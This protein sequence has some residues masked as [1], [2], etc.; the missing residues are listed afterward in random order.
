MKVKALVGFSGVVTMSKD[1][2]L[3]IK[4]KEIVEDL[5]QAGFVE[6]IKDTKKKVTK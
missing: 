1:E 4:D 3:E 2:E 5:L 6:E